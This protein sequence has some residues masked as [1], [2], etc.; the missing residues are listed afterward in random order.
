M[1]ALRAL[2]YKEY[3]AHFGAYILLVVLTF[4]F[5]LMATI[6]DS[7]DENKTS[8]LVVLPFFM[9]TFVVIAASILGKRL[10]VD[11]YQLHTHEFLL[12]L[13]IRRS[14]LLA[15]KYLLGLAGLLLLTA[16]VV[17]VVI[18]AAV[19]TEPIGFQFA[20]YL[21]LRSLGFLVFWWGFCFTVS[22]TGRFRE[23][24]IWGLLVFWI[25]SVSVS[26][27]DLFDAWPFHLVAPQLMPF[28]REIFPLKE[29]ALSVLLG[30]ALFALGLWLGTAQDGRLLTSLSGRLSQREKAGLGF[31]LVASVMAT[32]VVDL[33]KPK[34]PYRFESEEVLRSEK[35]PLEILYYEPE[36]KPAAEKLSGWLEPLLARLQK[37]LELQKMPTTRIVL[38]HQLDGLSREVVKLDKSDG[39][40]I[41]CNFA[42]GDFDR[43]EIGFMAVHT[44]LNRATRQ[45]AVNGP[46]HWFLDGFSQ[47]WV[48][49]APEVRLLESGWV[50]RASLPTAGTL[51]QWNQTMDSVGERQSNSL[52]FSA[53]HFMESKFGR[54]AVIKLAKAHFHRKVHRDIRESVYLW[55]H[56]PKSVFKKSTGTDFDAF[57]QDW[58]G[59]I[60]GLVPKLDG[61]GN[62]RV[63]FDIGAKAVTCR[64]VFQK[65][66]TRAVTSASL[67]HIKLKPSQSLIE[68]NDL[69][70]EAFVWVP[71]ET[72][73]EFTLPDEYSP[74]D[75][76]WLGL[77]LHFA[78]LEH[79]L[80]VGSAR[81]TVTP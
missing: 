1:R 81:A 66:P 40:L 72:N 19:G 29:F 77:D 38:S 16:G 24:L 80:R 68:E 31:L 52:A 43:V 22:L 18:F 4:G 34:E 23:P 32:S 7:T 20:S 13:P 50:A 10:V 6:R 49:D 57:I 39:T 41:R 73:R 26:D 79:P 62:P 12:G 53:V 56:S 58:Q 30:L 21:S 70:R 59:W 14:H 65:P 42:A 76:V 64:L 46:N 3:R 78:G 27:W 28:E 11:E 51:T 8:V 61:F 5:A 55:T 54:E 48:E 17:S 33:K 35:V 71:G 74:G 2:L 75:L 9:L 36:S 69:K 67:L 25:A 15:I 47:W 63:S 37:E 44:L 45:R 60:K